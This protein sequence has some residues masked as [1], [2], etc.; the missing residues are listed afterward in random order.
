MTEAVQY[1]SQIS[2]L[3]EAF[4]LIAAKKPVPV[5]L[6]SAVRALVKNGYVLMEA[7]K[8]VFTQRGKAFARALKVNAQTVST[9]L[10]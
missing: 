10:K 5:E 3:R 1:K 4:A 6:Q 8:P 7:H 9:I 2:Q